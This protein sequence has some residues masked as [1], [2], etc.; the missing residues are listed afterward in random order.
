[1]TVSEDDETQ[2]SIAFTTARIAIF[3]PSPTGPEKNATARDCAD[4]AAARMPAASVGVETVAGV[5]TA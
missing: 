3:V 4:H 2:T 1:M 5:V